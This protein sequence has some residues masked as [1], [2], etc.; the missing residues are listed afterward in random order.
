MKKIYVSILALGTV[1][2]L[3]AQNKQSANNNFHTY[4]G[5]VEKISN[6]DKA[7]GDTLFWMPLE[8]YYINPTDEATFTIQTEDAD[9]LTLNTNVGTLS[10]DYGVFFSDDP[11]DIFPNQGDVDTA[12]FWYAVSWFTPAAAASNWME[13]GPITVPSTGVKLSWM[14]KMYDKDYRDGYEVKA[15]VFGIDDLDFTDAAIFSQ[16]DNQGPLTDTS[17]T[18]KQ[19]DVPANY[20]G[21]QVYFAFHH[22]A[23]DM[24]IL[25]LDDVLVTE[26][27]HVN[28]I[29]SNSNVS[30]LSVYPNPFRVN[31]NIA[32]DL[33]NVS[34]VVLNMYDLSGKMVMQKNAGNMNAGVNRIE[35]DGS[36]LTSGV[37]YYT[38][39]INGSTTS[40]QK[41]VKM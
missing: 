3:H 16:G 10:Q 23:N 32:F 5:V 34:E 22:N 26:S 36:N 39:T 19:I 37:Y 21:Q 14:H 40:A 18:P 24:F 35:V 17:W 27:D 9:G 29:E 30:L 8:G 15:N 2:S 4:S 20:A 25:L 31:T 7:L 1:F 28:S 33:K 6:S 13:F 11:A 12:Y 41:I 38:L